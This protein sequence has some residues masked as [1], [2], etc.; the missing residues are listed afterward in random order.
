MLIVNCV[1]IAF[2]KLFQKC[3]LNL[4]SLSD[5]IETDTPCSQIVSR[6]YNLQNS[7]SVK[8]IHTARKMCQLSEPVHNHPHR[9]MPSQCPWQVGHK[10]HHDLLPLPLMDKNFGFFGRYF[11][12]ISFFGEPRKKNAQKFRLSDFSRKFPTFSNISPKF[13]DFF[14]VFSFCYFASKISKNCFWWDSNPPKMPRS[15]TLQPPSH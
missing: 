12:E 3:V 1:P 13:S 11:A 7:S 5:M 6:I 2:W 10:V 14:T 9:I 4:G 15:G 8:V